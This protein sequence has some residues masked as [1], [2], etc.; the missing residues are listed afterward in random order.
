MIRDL[1]AVDQLVTQRV[2]SLESINQA[3]RINVQAGRATIFR[4]EVDLA[5]QLIKVSHLHY[6]FHLQI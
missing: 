3:A 2:L 6:Y 1:E 4:T 5:Y